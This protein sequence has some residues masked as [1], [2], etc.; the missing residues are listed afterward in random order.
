MKKITNSLRIAGII[1]L[2]IISYAGNAQKIF[3]DYD[4]SADLKGFKTYSWLAPGDSI[5]NRERQDKLYGG[6]IVYIANQQLKNKGMS[7][8]DSQPDA[9]FV[10]STQVDEK[11][12]YTQRPTLSVGVSAAV[13]TNNQVINPGYN[14]A[15][16]EAMGYSHY[17]VGGYAP[18]A[19]G[20]IIATQENDGKLI[21][22]MYNA[23][24][25]K[26][27]W[28]GSINKKFKATEDV[29]KLINDYTIKIFKKFPIKN[30]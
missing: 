20:E 6:S 13:P 25:G 2:I 27:V 15:S 21:F 12:K 1:S 28:T 26:I 3:S 5:L 30:K 24:T 4:K 8:V 19:G 22:D 9:I 16:A 18:V 23:K 29:N 10:F 14:G 17:Y 11:T 7:L